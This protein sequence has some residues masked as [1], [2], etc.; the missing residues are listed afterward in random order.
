MTPDVW[1]LIAFLVLLIAGVPVAFSL[2]L[3]GAVGIVTGLSPAML[4]TLGTNT[5][6]S[7]AKYPLI[8]IPLFILTGLIFERAGVAA[9]LVRFAQALIGPRHGGLA[10]VAVVVCMIMGGMS[11]SGP[12]D[13]AAVAMVMLPSMTRAG[14]PRPFSATLIASSASTAILIPP[15]VALILYSIVVPGVDLRA[16]FAAGL[17]PGVLAGASLLI[18]ALWL[19]R[20]YGWEDPA[21]MERPP[22]GKS[23]REALPALFAPVI[24][25]GGLRSGLFTPTE[26]AVVAV[27]YGILVG[28]VLTR[29]LSLKDLWGLMGEAAVVSGV[30]MLII[31]LAGIFAWSGTMLGTFRHLAEWVIGLSDNG[32][33]LLLL[34][35]LA[36]LAAGMLL[37]AISIYLIM[38]PILIPVMQH[39]GWNPV[40]FG[41][42]LAMNIAIG[43][44]TPPVAVNLMVT[45][46]VAK[47]RLEQ[48]LG[49]AMVFVAAMASALALVVIFPE[50]AL[51]LPRVLGYNV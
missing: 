22:I 8:A 7:V 11:G 39:F 48:T 44:F 26:A 36:V 32:T 51:W 18:P 35:M 23:F 2:G 33:L 37:D 15:S 28:L 38:M 43:Q 1:M 27:A 14:Y 21:E 19:S 29:E 10:V 25:L 46:E 30:V 6:N 34:I 17:F 50:I 49:W 4:A 12:A 20:R 47:V 3:S 9:R 40:W 16:L 13:A 31:A 5:Y 24:I 42:L 41:I 45:T